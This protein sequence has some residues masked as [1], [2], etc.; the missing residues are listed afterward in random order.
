[1]SY[2]QSPLLEKIQYKG[3]NAFVGNEIVMDSIFA[4]YKNFEF[5]RIKYDSLNIF[6]KLTLVSLKKL[7]LERNFF[8]TKSENLTT[9]N[10]VFEKRLENQTEKHETELLYYKEKSKGKFKTLLYGTA[11]GGLIVAILIK[12]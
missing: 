11:I 6:S 10:I 4:K 9:T 3:N 8:K 7:E 1:M 5:L 12:K 2:S